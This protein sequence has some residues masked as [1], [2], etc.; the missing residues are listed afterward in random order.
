VL[1]TG[2]LQ[3]NNKN[4]IREGLKNNK[5]PKEIRREVNKANPDSVLG[6]RCKI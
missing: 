4:A 5:P 1:H 3:L 6:P 2:A